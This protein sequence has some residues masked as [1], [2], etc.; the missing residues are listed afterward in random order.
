M[1]YYIG[2]GFENKMYTLRE[3]IQFENAHGG[4][5]TSDRYVK[6][7]STNYEQAY[8]KAVEYAD[9]QNIVLEATKDIYTDCLDPIIRR[10][11]EHLAQ[12]K[13]E[14]EAK[15]E[16]F[17][18]ANPV[19]ADAWNTL[20]DDQET[21]KIVGW[22]FFDM[23][24][25][26]YEKGE[27]SVKQ[28]DLCYDLLEK[29][30]ERLEEKKRQAQITAQAQPVPVTEERIKFTGE[31]LNV[32]GDYLRL[33]NGLE[34][35]VE[36]CLFLDDRG[37]KLWGSKLAE[38]GD[39]ISFD[40]TVSVSKDDEKFGFFKRASKVLEEGQDERDIK[41]YMFDFFDWGKAKYNGKALKK[42]Y[43][44]L[45]SERQKNSEWFMDN[46]SGWR[47]FNG[48][49]SLLDL[50]DKSLDTIAKKIEDKLGLDYL[51]S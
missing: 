16:D 38:K 28:I 19:L 45:M 18:N 4:I 33:D 8:T 9:A 22:L 23:E 5:S 24:K 13:L 47:D 27:L 17:L 7:L 12:L 34:V 32:R 36:K 35:T 26:L 41:N 15:V 44:I 31:V 48:Y 2:T 6:N 1:K 30:I 46:Q 14:K 11:P 50:D 39:R 21:K 3:Y 51:N 40:A 37:F 43:R 42:V 49:R 29:G 20:C 10:T 25:Q